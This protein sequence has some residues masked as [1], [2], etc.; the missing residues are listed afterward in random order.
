MSEKRNKIFV[1]VTND[2]A[3]DQRVLKVCDF[4]T[5]NGFQVHLIG[6]RFSHS[7]SVKFLPYSTTRWNMLFKKGALFY[8]F[9]NIRLFFFLLFRKT[10]HILSNDLDTLLACA[11]IKVFRK[12]TILYHDAH[13]Y[14]TEVPE[15]VD[16]KF[17]QNTWKRIERF[18]FPKV[19]YLYTVNDS[20]AQLYQKKYNLEVDVVRNI[21]SSKNIPVQEL[22]REDIGLKK[23]QFVGIIQGAGINID[24]G[25]EEVVTAFGGL[26]E[27]KL[28]IVGAGD[29]IPQLKKEVETNKWNNIIF[30]PKQPYEKLM[31]ITRL[32]N[33]GFT[34]DKDTNINYKFSLPNKIFDYIHVGVPIVASDLIEVSKIIREHRVGLITD[35]KVEN[36]ITCIQKMASNKELIQ[37]FK[38]NCI[39][40]SKKLT[41]ENECKVLR[42]IYLPIIDNRV[43]S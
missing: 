13:E 8:A 30:L 16:R 40:A 39:V 28:L 11:C 41:W 7:L 14:F 18:S 27:Y 43:K 15:I 12:K 1:A 29:V 9:Y 10:P 34:M 22:K 20:I 36:I 37:E 32:A 33:V 5:E 26:P 25:A 2:L 21:S 4:L 35:H 38:K 31:Q 19:D 6:R 42:K 23:D 24:R 3:T 17:I